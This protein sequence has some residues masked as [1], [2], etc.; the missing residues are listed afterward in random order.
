MIVKAIYKDNSHDFFRD[1]ETKQNRKY[2][3]LFEC[4]DRLAE[5]RIKKGLVKK[6]TKKEEK[7][8]YDSIETFDDG[9]LTPSDDI[10]ETNEDDGNKEIIE[11]E[12]TSTENNE[13]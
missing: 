9:D 11:E 2:G 1:K 3:T 6:A 5:E 8:Y 7:E 10:P 12:N 13:E 4:D